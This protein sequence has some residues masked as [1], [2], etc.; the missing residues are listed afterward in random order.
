MEKNS[1]SAIIEIIEEIEDDFMEKKP[2]SAEHFGE[3]RDFWWNQ[4]FLELMAKRW[5]V[6]KIRSVLDVGCG[7]GHW[8]RILSRILSKQAKI[9]GID[10][11][12]AWVTEAQERTK[13]QA[14]RFHYQQGLGEAIP[15]P[16]ET[17]DMVTCQ[18]VLIHV[19]DVLLVLKE[20]T[21]VLK[22][23]GL[24]VVAEPNNCASD[25]IFD[26]ISIHNPVEDVIALI[27][28]H[29]ICERGKARLKL[30]FESVGDIIPLYFQQLNLDNIQIYLSD[31]TTPLIPPYSDEE[32]QI[33]IR[34]TKEWVDADILLWSKPET[35]KY[36]LA[37]GGEAKEFEPLWELLKHFWEKTL[38]AIEEGTYATAGGN[39]MYLISGRKSP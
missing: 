27:R 15:F 1:N 23:G 35:K 13:S 4:D 10:R 18:T 22:P 36:F 24:L 29:M 17:F 7:M 25:L 5:K 30:G 12:H 31:K 8:S 39:I 19:P 2:H 9:T 32:Q 21:R 20:M 11:E 26:S 38:K 34:Q 28:F 16:D 14:N 33:W 3:Q 37:G 6:D